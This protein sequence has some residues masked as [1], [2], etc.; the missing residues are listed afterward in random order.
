MCIK[1]CFTGSSFAVPSAIAAFT[2]RME[3]RILFICDPRSSNPACL[4]PPSLQKGEQTRFN[5]V[6]EEMGVQS[7]APASL[8]AL[9]Q[10]AEASRAQRVVQ[11]MALTLTPIM[12]KGMLDP[13]LLHRYSCH[14]FVPLFSLFFFQ[15]VIP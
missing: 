6:V 10:G 12:E 5:A 2:V 11:R 13:P 7:E 14:R 4:P 3:A 8:D 1:F 15:F 9:L